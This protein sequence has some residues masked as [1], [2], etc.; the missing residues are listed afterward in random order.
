MKH[1]DK[2][3][4]LVVWAD[5]WMRS[6]ASMEPGEIDGA[7]KPDIC[8]LYGWILK[9]DEKGVM[10]GAE[11]T[12]EDNTFRLTAFVPRAMVLEERQLSLT[13]KRVASLGRTP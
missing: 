9:S 7:H 10:V 12:P 13:K 2:P 6:T 3:F 1:P 5:A 4:G 11:W 8:Y